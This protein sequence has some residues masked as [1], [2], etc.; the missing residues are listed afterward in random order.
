MVKTWAVRAVRFYQKY[1]SPFIIPSCRFTPSCSSYA[2]QAFET[3]GFLKGLILTL[4]RI[5][6]CHPFHPGGYDPVPKTLF[7]GQEAFNRNHTVGG[8]YPALQY[9]LPPIQTKAGKR[10]ST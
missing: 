6:K 10:G 5:F 1:F 8:R 3:H 9:P 7:D 4:V 2:L